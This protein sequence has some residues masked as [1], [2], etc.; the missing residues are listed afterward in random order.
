MEEFDSQQL[1]WQLKQS[2]KGE[3]D[4]TI[5]Q[6]KELTGNIRSQFPSS[7]SLS[8][9][10]TSSDSDTSFCSTP[11]DERQSASTAMR[12]HSKAIKKL[13]QWVQ[14]RTRKWVWPD[15]KIKTALWLINCKSFLVLCCSNLM[16][17]IAIYCMLCWL[18]ALSGGL[19]ETD[20]V[21]WI[22]PFIL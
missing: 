17:D 13:L 19:F 5:F 14:K 15:I 18:V 8:S 6:I 12:E 1:N 2:S 20:P 11:S 3:Y 9:I 21:H 10:P 7:S 16:Q 22:S 4:P